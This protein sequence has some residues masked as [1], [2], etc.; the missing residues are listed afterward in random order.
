MPAIEKPVH[1]AYLRIP[2]VSAGLAAGAVHQEP[3]HHAGD[4]GHAVSAIARLKASW[5]YMGRDGINGEIDTPGLMT[6]LLAASAS[7]P[8]STGEKRRSY[9]SSGSSGTAI[10]M[11]LSFHEQK[12]AH[13]Q[14]AGKRNQ[15]QKVRRIPA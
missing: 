6:G 15:F 3:A 10:S 14:K 7:N 12:A 8:G 2:A 11:G 5:I 9:H 1:L 4:D 13:A